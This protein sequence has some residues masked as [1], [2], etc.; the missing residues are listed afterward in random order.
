[1]TILSGK[2]GARVISEAYSDPTMLIDR[3]E[4]K[5]GWLSNFHTHPVV[6]DDVEYPSG[7]HAF[8]ALK[9]VDPVEREHVRSAS[10]PGEA[11]RRGQKV[12]LRVSRRE[13]DTRLR[14]DVMARVQAAKYA[15][16]DL[17]AR[18]LGTGDALLIE[19]NRHHDQHWGDCGCDVHRPWPGRNQL[20]A[21]LIALRSK[22]AGHPADRWVRVAVTG[23]RPQHLTDEQARW[24]QS[25]LDRLAV[26][27]R[28][29][30]GA[31]VAISGGALGADTWWARA[32]LRADLRLWAYVP[33]L[34]QPSRW[35]PQDQR[36]WRQIL[37]LADRTLVLAADY[38]VRLLH[39][40]NG[41]MIRDA[42]L[43][44]AVWDPA[45]TTGGTASA[46]RDARAAGKTLV[47]VDVAARKTRIE[48]PSR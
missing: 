17:R 4:G 28:D 36:T 21:T 8:N 16:P 35:Q 26:K 27:V 5:D 45:K 30:H 43:L 40:R 41:F 6:L 9:T 13:W 44:I 34:A 19:G 2:Q 42:D 37:S 20:G 25:E 15:E 22:L 31:Q 3:F 48:R 1:M 24:A 11:K 7:E 32:A 47:L 14:Y 12:T 46:V 18:L 29:H 38:D 39:A 33:C 10:T 23:H